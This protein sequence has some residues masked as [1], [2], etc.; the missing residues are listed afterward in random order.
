MD[1]AHSRGLN[2]YEP[3]DPS[4]DHDTKM[5]LMWRN[6]AEREPEIRAKILML[7]KDFF[8]AQN[9]FLENVC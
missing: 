4:L 3:E 1:L 5:G 8:M 9:T 6:L 7:K 2:Q